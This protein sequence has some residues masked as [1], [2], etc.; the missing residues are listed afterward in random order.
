MDDP[1]HRPCPPFGQ[2]LGARRRGAAHVRRETP[3]Q[4]AYHYAYQ[5]IRALPTLALAVA[6]GHGGQQYDR[7]AVGAQ[8]AVRESVRLLIDFVVE[9]TDPRQLLNNLRIDFARILRKNWR[10]AVLQ[11]ERGIA[12]DGV[13]IEPYTL[14]KR[15]GT[16][17]L[18]VLLQPE[19][20]FAGQLGD[21]KVVRIQ[22]D[23]TV[24]EPFPADPTLL[25]LETHSLC[26]EACDKLWQTAVWTRQAEETLLLTTDGLSDS[27]ANQDEFHRFAGSLQGLLAEQGTGYV[28][29]QLPHWLDRYSHEG[30]GDDMT[31]LL[32]FPG[33]S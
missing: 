14:I 17:L 16:T 31:V 3:C 1:V 2:L 9:F 33:V 26:S 20:V 30:S 18:T 29:E 28:A 22:A 24:Q 7:S 5:E 8:L 19:M 10:E 13:E 4:D 23:G 25:G 12:A 32:V 27:F 11:H 21:G 6:D 15:Y